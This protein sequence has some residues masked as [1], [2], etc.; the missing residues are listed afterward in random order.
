MEET[1]KAITFKR[2]P[3]LGQPKVLYEEWK[4]TFEH[5]C[6]KYK[7]KDEDRTEFL[8]TLKLSQLILLDL[9]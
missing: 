2:L 9:L 4:F 7:V 1:T 6:R 3:I 5:W 8:I